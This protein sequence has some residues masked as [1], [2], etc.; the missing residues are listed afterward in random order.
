MPDFPI[1]T[2]TS[3]PRVQS[4]RSNN[5]SRRLVL[6]RTSLAPLQIHRNWSTPPWVFQHVHSR[7]PTE[8]ENQ[9]VLLTDA[10]ANSSRVPY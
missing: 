3:A 2:I 8:Q 7:G 6:Y 4:R 1:H 10:V 5:R 9:I